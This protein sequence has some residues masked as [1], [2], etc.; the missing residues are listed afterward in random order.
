MGRRFLVLLLVVSLLMIVTLPTAMAQPRVNNSDSVR[1]LDA[2]YADL[3][4]DGYEDDI[5]ILVEFSFPSS[6]PSRV[7]LNLWICLPSGLTYNFRISV[8]RAPSQS[9]LQIDCIDMASECGWYTV[10]MLASIMGTGNGKM[11]ITDDFS[12]DPPTGGGPGLP[13]VYAYF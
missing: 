6:D 4:S 5:K 8:Y 7:D 2:Y 9:V 1:I 10:T 3:D 13:T 12:F 11:Y